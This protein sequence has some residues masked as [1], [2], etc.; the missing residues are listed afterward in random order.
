MR[1]Y[2]KLIL[3]V[4]LANI[5]FAQKTTNRIYHPFTGT[6]LFS[7]N[8]GSTLART[9]YRDFVLDYQGQVS[10]EYF[11]PTYSKS[12]L[13]LKGYGS[14]LF[15]NNKD[16]RNTPST[17]RTEITS[18]GGAIIYNLSLGEVIFPQLSVGGSYNFYTPKGDNGVTL[19]PLDGVKRNEVNYNVDLGFRIPLTDELIFNLSGGIQISPK[20]YLDNKVRGTDN[21]LFF[22]AM[23]GFSYA[24]FGESD[25]DNDGILDS[26]DE[27]PGTKR[28]I[29]VDSKG[30][31]LD[32]DRD[33]V[34]DYMDECSGTPEGVKV[35]NSGCPV[36]TDRDGVPDYM[37]ICPG[38]ASGVLIDEYGCPRDKD[39]DG[40][41]DYQDD[42]PNTAKGIPV[43]RK[44]CPLDSDSDGVA[45]YL[46]KCPNTPRNIQVDSTGCELQKEAV[47]QDA[48]VPQIPISKPTP[49]RKEYVLSGATS[50]GP[51]KSD[52]LSSA[53]VEL[54]KL[55]LVMNEEP[56][57]KWL[58]EGH[59]DA[60]GNPEKN[61]A[62]S[63]KRANAVLEFF[64]DRGISRLRFKIRGMGSDDPVAN[65][66]TESG[67]AKNRRVKIIRTE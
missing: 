65:N 37:D 4:L 47:V 42:C 60:Q 32:T 14:F 61:R 7:V 58:I 43:D 22:N 36:D 10:F 62:L 55:V 25:N 20:D 23:A 35:S 6:L 40:V 28:G 15:L 13:G 50:F 26:E 19:P 30:C 44:G 52:L 27:C 38:T 41:A 53:Y 67:R 59:T 51:G 21:D 1:I 46:D 2:S 5:A 49:A 3:V 54:D 31:P 11:I 9:D 48:P 34:A 63:L 64:V 57:S 16:S 12:S 33:G 39:D 56:K 17:V 24:F 66:N 8:G 45:D 18:F 29:K